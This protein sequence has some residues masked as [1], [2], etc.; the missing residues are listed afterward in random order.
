MKPAKPVKKPSKSQARKRGKKPAAV[1]ASISAYEPAPRE[2]LEKLEAALPVNKVQRIDYAAFC[3][4][5]LMLVDKQNQ[6]IDFIPNAVQLRYL[7][8]DFTGRDIILKA[9][10]QGFSTAIDAMIA[11]DFIALKPNSY[12]V[13]VADTDD[14]AELLLERVKLFIQAY[15]TKN[16]VKLQLKYNSRYELYHTFLNSRITIGTAKNTDFGRS[17]TITNLH[18]SE[19]AYY[20]DILRIM[21]GAGQAVIESGKLILETTA[22]GYNEF[23]TLWDEAVNGE[24]SFK[25]IFYKASDF[26]DAKF[27]EQKRHDLGRLYLQEYPET[28]E[29]AF[30]TSGDAFFNPEILRVYQKATIDPLDIASRLTYV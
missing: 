14:N 24:S 3:K 7:D 28:P 5:E 6:L 10:Q 21:A 11:A 30:L 13:I 2:Q 17:R 26:Y 16:D 1:P 23:K 19:A 25:A 29:D 9:R 18:L 15:E 8:T 27:L 4:N 12:S 22:N 20:P